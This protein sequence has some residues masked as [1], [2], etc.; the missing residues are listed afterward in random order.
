MRMRKFFIL[1]LSVL[2][3]TLV[4][5][6]NEEEM[7]QEPSNEEVTEEETNE[8]E[9]VEE[10][11]SV[12]IEEQTFEKFV[13]SSFS[14]EVVGVYAKLTNNGDDPVS[15]YNVQTTFY[16]SNDDIIYIEEEDSMV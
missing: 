10:D 11:L 8:P 3:I 6:G 12:D 15:L 14:A 9:E 13:N 1:L 7:Q 5:C 2:L 4:A 16:D